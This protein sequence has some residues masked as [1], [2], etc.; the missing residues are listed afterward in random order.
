MRSTA[1]L[2]GDRTSKE[3]QLSVRSHL[4]TREQPWMVVDID[5]AD[6]VPDLP[7]VDDKGKR[8]GG[9]FVTVRVFTEPVGGLWVA[10]SGDGLSRQVLGR[11]VDVEVGDKVRARLHAAGCLDFADGVPLEGV[12]V[13]TRPAWLVGR[14]A[15]EASSMHLTIALCTRDRIDGVRLCLASLQEQTYPRITVLVIDNAPT[16][17]RVREFVETAHF[18]VPVNYVVERTPGLSYARNRAVGLCQTELLAF[19]D[20]DEVAC[21]YWA[22]EV[23][24]GFVED[25]AVDCVTGVVTPSELDTAAQQLFERYGGHSKGRGF[26]PVTFDGRQLGKNVA[27]FPLPAFGAGANMSFRVLA[28]RDL[29]GFDTAL[30]AGTASLGGEDTEMLSNILLSGRRIA[31]RPTALVRHCH[32]PTHELLRAQFYGVGV[33]LT[34]FYAAVISRHPM[35][36]FRLFAL[37]PRAFREVFGSRGDRAGSIGDSFPPDLLAANRKGMTRGPMAYW[38]TRMRQHLQQKI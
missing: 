21:P 31:Y 8:I 9:A 14:D 38:R 4:G 10:V 11:I 26:E 23:V 24:R 3:S 34:A 20:D 30:G 33:G 22:S 6:G 16:D 7:A 35:Y 27:L 5:I 12:N 32:R 25:P 2:T 29:G 15:A 1:S 36:L 28:I 18:K 37:V 17:D 13:P 19:I